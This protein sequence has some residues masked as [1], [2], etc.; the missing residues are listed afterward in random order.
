M[1]RILLF[2]ILGILCFINTVAS[3]YLISPNAIIEG[4][5]ISHKEMIFT[6]GI[7][8]FPDFK[9][10]LTSNVEANSKVYVASG[11][12]SEDITI[13]TD[14][15]SVIGNNAFVDWS[16]TRKDESVI[17]GTIFVKS[18]NVIINGFK[19][20]GNGRIEST[21]GTN[22]SP[23]SGIKVLYNYFAGSTV[24]RSTST[25]LVEIGNII[26]NA[27]VNTISSQCRYQN[28]EASHNYFEGDAT[29]Y[30]NCISFGGAFGTTTV[31]D[32]YF[33]DGGTS[34]YFAN[35][36]GVL[37]I[38]NNVFKNV[39]KTTYSAPD[40]G[41]KG[42]FCIALYRSAYANT[43]TANI[44][45]N[46]FDGCYGQESIF[47]LI[48]VYQGQS[49][50][51]NEVK[52]VGYRINVNENTFKNKTTILPSATHNQAGQNLLLYSDNSTGKDIKYNLSN[53][54]YDNRFY[55]FAWVTLDDGQGYREIYADQ[56]T[57]FD[58][59]SKMSTFGTSVL[60][61][62]DVA[63]HATGVSL[64][65]ATVIQ[66]FDIDPITGD[67]YFI[68]KM[69]TSRNTSYNSAYGFSSTHDGLTVTRVPCTKID[70]YAY[71]YSTSIQ[72][73]EIGYGG[74]GTN[75][76]FVRDKSGQGWLWS[77]AKASL[78][79]G[80]DISGATARWQF[81]SGTDINLDGTGNTDSGVQYFN[82]T[83][84]N[85]YPAC[86]ETSRYLC[87]R[88][89]G[90]GKNTYHIYDLDAALEGKK[91]LIK[92]VELTIGDYVNSSIP[93][94]NGYNTWA[95]Q[96]FDIKGDYIYTLEGVADESTDA[97]TSGDPTLVVTCYNWRTN[98]YCYRSR[99]NYGRIN[100][101]TSGEPEGMVIRHD[102]YGHANLYI[103]VVNG[104]AGSRK[105][106]VYKYII[107]YHTEYD[108]TN[109][110]ATKKGDDTYTKTYLDTDYEGINFTCDTDNIELTASTINEAPSKTITITNGEYL[111]GQ[112]YGVITGEDGDVFSVKMSSN[113]AFSATA[114][115]TVTFN[116][117]EIKSSYNATLRL[118]S[119]LATTNVESNDIVIPISA[120]YTG[121][122]TGIKNIE[123]T[124]EVKTIVKNKTLI[125]ENIEVAT[126]DIYTM[127]GTNIASF[128]ESNIANLTSLSGVYIAV[129]TDKNNNR[130][131]Q[132]VVL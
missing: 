74:H 22:K 45:A 28:C 85:D 54:H 35:A 14:G 106:N 86:D 109:A 96:S 130:H 77:G 40:G 19:F 51:T 117:K 42:D 104:P 103:A 75:M 13:S 98:K 9:S 50:T 127:S 37:N 90:S 58:L 7:N 70:G 23:L 63:T 88:T 25:P 121:A 105:A 87:I 78:R 15:L 68:Q 4:S 21:A 39:G 101:L 126:I 44:V 84:S 36:Q 1:K 16:E 56:F 31:L 113:N 6:V 93:N 124:D 66:S 92:T 10:F 57:R 20:T 17:T 18:S 79:D 128:S 108:A 100:N 53:N 48:R 131:I 29:H 65:A 67:M 30:P 59:G 119:P 32:N 118:F 125:I 97:I 11:T 62:T 72:S 114:T 83:G 95:F 33:Y 27:D 71:T 38:K 91:T 81:K 102:K 99:L 80:D 82:V 12:Y 34:V 107:D 110:T 111:F 43:T 129:I 132:K 76:C 55:R 46:E 2:S 41:N 61:G 26:A 49:G 122:T 94:D 52:P 116:P 8:A 60:T 73:M 120:K 112:W 3:N 123:N 115:A 47:P 69:N 89:S 64:G 5:E 24:K